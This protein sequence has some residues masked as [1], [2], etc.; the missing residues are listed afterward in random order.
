MH[1]CLNW[2]TG[3]FTTEPHINEGTMV[4][5]R[6]MRETLYWSHLYILLRK[7]SPYM[8]RFRTLVSR[9]RDAGLP[10]YWEGD[11]IR[12]YMS[13]RLQL[14]IST[15][16]ILN[17]N[18]GPMKLNLDHLQGVFFLLVLGEAMASMAFFAE[19]TFGRKNK[20]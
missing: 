4:Y 9:V 16:R 15:S 3:H 19:L 6:V 11:V 20:N 5:R 17:G 10:L 8:H 2:I 14:Q 13:E 12:R 7:G 1:A 18:L